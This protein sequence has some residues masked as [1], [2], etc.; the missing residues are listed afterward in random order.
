[1]A[2]CVQ[3]ARQSTA[4]ALIALL[5]TAHRA[6]NGLSPISSQAALRRANQPALSARLET[7]ALRPA[8]CA[9]RPKARSCGWLQVKCL[10]QTFCR[11]AQ[12]PARHRAAPI[13][14]T[15]IIT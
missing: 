12:W 14:L 5:P 10:A 13:Q 4:L 11:N 15:K 6:Q 1:M 8:P 3:R 9:P 2:A 7:L